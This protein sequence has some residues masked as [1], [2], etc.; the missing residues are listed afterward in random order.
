MWKQNK[1]TQIKNV[2]M[3]PFFFLFGPFIQ[4]IPGQ[5]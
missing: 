4:I 3:Y 2:Y 1:F 5:L